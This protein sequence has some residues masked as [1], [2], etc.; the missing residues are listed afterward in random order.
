MRRRVSD[1]G[2]QAF[3]YESE[4]NDCSVVALTH[5]LNVTYDVA[6]K[7]LD[8]AGRRKNKGWYVIEF[9]KYCGFVGWTH[10]EF[11]F[12]RGQR[13]TEEEF[14]EAHPKGRWLIY[15]EGHLTALVDGVIYDNRPKPP[16]GKVQIAWKMTQTS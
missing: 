10:K 13:M 11:K 5:A 8:G 4:K 15:T 3:G 12:P 14:A 9:F 7:M 6:Y 1:G 2:R 16:R